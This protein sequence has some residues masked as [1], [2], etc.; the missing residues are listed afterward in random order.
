[1]CPIRTLQGRTKLYN[2]AQT[3]LFFIPSW[4]FLNLWVSLDG[5]C[6]VHWPKKSHTCHD[7][8]F[9]A[10]SYD[11]SAEVAKNADK[12]RIMLLF[13]AEFRHRALCATRAGMFSPM[14]LWFRQAEFLKQHHTYTCK[15]R[16]DLLNHRS[17]PRINIQVSGKLRLFELLPLHGE[18]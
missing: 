5:L 14:H 8:L 11:H 9:T 6:C 15:A 10:D 17:Q 18:L 7:H 16:R 4:L 12:I 2:L 13:T 3:H 1:M